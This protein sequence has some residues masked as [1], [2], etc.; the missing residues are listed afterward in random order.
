MSFKKGEILLNIKHYSKR[1]IATD[2]RLSH[3]PYVKHLPTLIFYILFII[4]K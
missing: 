1:I 4:M 2:G 3:Y